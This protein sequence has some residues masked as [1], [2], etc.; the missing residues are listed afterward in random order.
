MNALLSRPFRDLLSFFSRSVVRVV[1]NDLSSSIKEVPNDLF[2]AR[3]YPLSECFRLGTLLACLA[4]DEN[5][6]LDGR[7]PHSMRLRRLN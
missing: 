3:E 2:T 6:E 1:N 7:S 5:G 4:D